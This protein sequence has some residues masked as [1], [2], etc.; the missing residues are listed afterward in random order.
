MDPVEKA[1]RDAA[2]QLQTAVNAA[3]D[4]GYHVLWP[5]HGAPITTIALSVTGKMTD[6]IA[7]GDL[8]PNEMRV[9]DAPARPIP[10]VTNIDGSPIERDADGT[11]HGAPLNLTDEERAA[12]PP[13]GNVDPSEPADMVFGVLKGAPTAT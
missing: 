7:S 6:F 5:R 8:E 1:V 2:E 4:A 13:L 12:L 11:I 9:F 10:T 3:I